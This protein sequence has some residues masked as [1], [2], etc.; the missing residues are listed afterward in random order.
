MRITLLGNSG[1]GKSTLARWLA[2]RAHAPLLDLDTLAWEPGKIAVAR[3]AAAAVPDVVSFCTANASWVVEGCYADLIRAALA[4]AP[5]LL[6]LDP[7]EAR[8]LANCRARAWEPHKYASK[9][10]QD[11]RLPF[12]LTW[13]RAYYTRTGELSHAG[14]VATYEAYGGPKYRLTEPPLLDPPAAEVEALL[15]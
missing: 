14:H 12:L 6:F 5:V 1:S 3:P 13:V 7:G 2:A 9:A 15:D 4:F 8:C 10:A 11:E